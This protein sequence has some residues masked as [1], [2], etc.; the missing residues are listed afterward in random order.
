MCHITP[1][2]LFT[3]PGIFGGPKPTPLSIDRAYLVSAL[4]F[5]LRCSQE[6]LSKGDI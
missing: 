5:A 6:K 3:S 4:A 2:F 1:E